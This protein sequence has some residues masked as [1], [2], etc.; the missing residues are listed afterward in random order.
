MHR[1]FLTGESVAEEREDLRKSLGVSHLSSGSC[2][3]ETAM[4]IASRKDLEIH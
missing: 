1:M 2:R 4:M 3:S